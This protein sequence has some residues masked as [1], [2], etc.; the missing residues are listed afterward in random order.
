MAIAALASTATSTAASTAP[1]GSSRIAQ[2][3]DG[4][5]ATVTQAAGAVADGVS[6]TVSFSGQALHALEQA[7]EFVLD[8]AEGLAAGAWHGLEHAATSAEQVGEAVAGAVAD[9]ATEVYGATKT[10]AKELGH[11]AAV[12]FHA[13]GEAVSDVASG[14]VMA[15]SAV[16]K[17]LAALV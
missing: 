6:A 13:T 11:Y 2:A 14:A 7:G 3:G 1:T 12:G 17:T 4:A 8:G 5:A 10:A 9:G 16:G 15:A